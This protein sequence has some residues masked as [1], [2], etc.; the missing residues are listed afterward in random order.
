MILLTMLQYHAFTFMISVQLLLLR[1]YDWWQFC[2]AVVKQYGVAPCE[3]PLL[4][5]AQLR[6]GDASLYLLMASASPPPILLQYSRCVAIMQYHN[7]STGP[8]A[9]SVVLH[10]GHTAKIYVGVSCTQVTPQLTTLQALE[11]PL[12]PPSSIPKHPLVLPPSIP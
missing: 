12:V 11:I 10:G 3:P 7:C 8:T 2:K 1:Y 6:L 9:G 4:N 5:G